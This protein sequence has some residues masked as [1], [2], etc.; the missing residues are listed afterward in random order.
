ML[1]VTGERRFVAKRDTAE[2][3]SFCTHEDTFTITIRGDLTDLLGL[4]GAIDRSGV[5]L[6]A[7]GYFGKYELASLGLCVERLLNPGTDPQEEADATR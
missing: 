5:F 7:R 2:T 1:E 4:S 6:W 3:P